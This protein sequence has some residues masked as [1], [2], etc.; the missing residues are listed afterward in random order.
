MSWLLHDPVVRFIAQLVVTVGLARLL[1][2]GARKL[3]QP[4]VTAEIVAGIVLGPSILGAVAPGLSAALFPA[5][6]LEA[7]GMVSQ[8]G[9]VL[10]VFLVGLELE[11]RQLRGRARATVSIALVGIAVP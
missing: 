11:P 8:L 10:F 4:S 9:V 5:S 3:G 1:A 7:L 6:S 2:R